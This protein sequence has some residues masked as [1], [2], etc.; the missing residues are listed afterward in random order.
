MFLFYDWPVARVVEVG[1]P[2][3]RRFSLHADNNLVLEDLL[4][5]GCCAEL[6]V[7]LVRPSGIERRGYITTL[8]RSRWLI[9]TLYPT[10]IFL[11]AM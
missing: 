11:I 1:G 10:D 8:E 7:W 3:K 2:N 5:R 6:I 9:G 4:E